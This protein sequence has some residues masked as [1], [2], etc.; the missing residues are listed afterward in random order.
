L[1]LRSASDL[2]CRPAEFPTFRLADWTVHPAL[3]RLTKDAGQEILEPRMMHVLVCLAAFPGEVLSRGLLLEAVWQDVIVGEEALTRAVSRLRDLLGDDPRHPRFIET[4]RGG[5]YRLI[6]TP[7]PVSSE[8]PSERGKR[9]D[10]RT[11]TKAVYFLLGLLA[12]ALIIVLGWMARPD[13]PGG[14]GALLA[15]SPFTSFPGSEG[16]PDFAPDGRTIVFNWTG[17]AD[18]AHGLFLMQRDTAEPRRLTSTTGHDYQ[19]CFSPDGQNIAFVRNV[20][21]ERTLRTVSVLGGP[22]RIVTR[23]ASPVFG[24]CWSPDGRTLVFAGLDPTNEIYN[25]QIVQLETL[26]VSGLTQPDL[27]THTGDS[28]PRFSPDGRALAFARCDH[29]GLRDLWIV[30]ASGGVGD[31][32]T[33]GLDNVNGFVWLPDGKAIIVAAAPYGQDGL[34]RVDPADGAFEL[35]PTST[36]AIP[37]QPTLSPD[38]HS[39]IFRAVTTDTDFFRQSIGPG[40]QDSKP[41][42]FL[43]S[44]RNESLPAWSWDGD[45]VAFVSD[46]TGHSEVWCA[47]SDG[48]DLRQVTRSEGTN[49][50]APLWSPDGHT[51]ALTL[52][53]GQDS[54]LELV[55]VESGLSHRLFEPTDHVETCCWSADGARIRILLDLDERW[56]LHDLVVESGELVPRDLF[57]SGHPRTLPA[58]DEFWFKSQSGEGLMRWAP[59]NPT[60]ESMLSDAAL[61]DVASWFPTRETLFTISRDA[62]QKRVVYA[63]DLVTGSEHRLIEAPASTWDLTVAPDRKTI[64]FSVLNQMSAD[65]MIISLRK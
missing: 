24:L 4:I 65:L 58:Q 34:Y 45:R 10:H 15:A 55:D 59:G 6:S 41:E 9:S 33:Y 25:L 16:Y 44:T 53:N 37:V 28:W 57:L 26:N 50:L 19:P 2:P 48:S 32:L 54:W 46:R 56:Q 30:S 29:A 14:N 43:G 47:R 35:L 20:D 21:G 22:T 1:A 3:N 52:K 60:P 8:A 17:V 64:L 27:A 23:P 7:V 18:Q 39:L 42:H 31:R 11:R 40:H 61:N 62:D 13:A 5:G 63:R 12:S 38:G 51:L 49:I 36:S